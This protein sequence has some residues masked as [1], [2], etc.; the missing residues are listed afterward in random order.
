M[1]TNI[2]ETYPI[3]DELLP[4]HFHLEDYD[5]NVDYPNWHNEL[6]LLYCINEGGI[7][8]CDGI[9]YNFKNNDIICI[10]PDQLHSSS[11]DAKFVYYCLIINSDFCKDN[12]I[13]I[14]KLKFHN[15]ISDEELSLKFS[16]L[17]D[18]YHK[19]DNFDSNLSDINLCKAHIRLCVLDI[20]V[21]LAKNYRFE[22]KS[23]SSNE[24]STDY[25]KKVLEFVSQNMS[26]NFS[27]DE[28][29]EHV[30]VSKY[31][32]VREFKRITG[33]TIVEQINILK[34]NEAKNLIAS[35]LSVSQ[36]ATQLGYNNLPYFSQMFKKHM[37]V[38][39]SKNRF[40]TLERI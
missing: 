13:N 3:K 22:G 25:V 28:I 31:H 36:A 11:T 17:V 29:A 38:P 4:F 23:T 19:L 7:V 14:S 21:Y 34:C 26:R 1:T 32:L 12:G 15:Y 10:N 40:V 6:E 2:Y 37:G 24:T 9:E 18:S 20:L 35:G 8:R 16:R 33:H 30:K 39:P 27:L 5:P